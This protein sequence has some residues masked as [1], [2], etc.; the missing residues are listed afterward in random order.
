MITW[1]TSRAHFQ[2][3]SLPERELKCGMPGSMTGSFNS[4]QVNIATSCT[5]ATNALRPS[6]YVFITHP[7]IRITKDHRNRRIL[8]LTYVLIR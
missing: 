5:R 3:L 4:P 1:F 6:G 2:K 7:R 8:M